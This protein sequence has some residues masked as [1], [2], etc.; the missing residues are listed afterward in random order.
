M[1]KTIIVCLCFYHLLSRVF[2]R[3]LSLC[4]ALIWKLMWAV[5]TIPQLT[6][7]FRALDLLF[8]AIAHNLSL[9]I[10]T[11]HV[12][13]SYKRSG[14]VILICVIAL[15]LVVF[16]FKAAGPLF[17][18]PLWFSV[19]LLCGRQVRSLKSPSF[20]ELCLMVSFFTL[21]LCNYGKFR[22]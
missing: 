6:S 7:S 9:L 20:F 21:F 1:F 10:H 16:N 17:T 18:V 19:S 2:L 13:F 5:P 11:L 8:S 4:D 14:F 3:F 15:F 12:W 22:Q